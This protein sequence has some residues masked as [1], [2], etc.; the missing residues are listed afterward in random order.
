MGENMTRTSSIQPAKDSPALKYAVARMAERMFAAE[1]A[2][3]RRVPFP[4]AGE[5]AVFDFRPEDLR[6]FEEKHGAAWYSVLEDRL[7]A[8]S[9]ATLLRCLEIGLKRAGVRGGLFPLSVD[10]NALPFP[11]TDAGEPAL[12]AITRTVFGK[13]RADLIAEIEAKLSAEA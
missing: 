4:P 2:A 13:S 11:I 1:L 3:K 8:S 6:E 10:P 7:L 9:P 12:D 5:G